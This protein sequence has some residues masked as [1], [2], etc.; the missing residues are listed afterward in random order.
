MI[1]H[2]KQT[3]RE[4]RWADAETLV[5]E[6][7]VTRPGDADLLNLHGIILHR[8]SRPTEALVRFEQA[9]DV[10]L[11]FPEA[12][13]N[14]ERILAELQNP[15][16]RYSVTVI[17]P[18]IGGVHLAQALQSVQEQTYPFLEHAIV[19]DGDQFR[20]AVEASLPSSPSKP[21]R[22][23]PLPSNTGARGF[24]GHRIYGALPHLLNSQFVAFLDEDN[25]FDKD[26]IASLMAHVTKAGLSWAYSLR[27]IVDANGILI[28]DD[29]CESLGQWPTWNNSDVH[30]VDV[31]CYLLR[32]DLAVRTSSLWYRRFRDGQS[33]DFL[34]CHDLLKNYPR[35]AT[36]GR[37][38]VNYRVGSTPSSVRAEFFLVGND[39]MRKR[40]SCAMPWRLT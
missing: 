28:T 25:W 36:N 16:P 6:A 32:R 18:T 4:R 38:T 3:L 9:T 31:N 24:N 5:A 30:L 23:Y 13:E 34:L 35:T 14:V 20:P 1:E 26:H 37:S 11:L 8:L 39:E 29:D 40:Y 21:I 33:P 12:W 22:V 19:I 2:I 27:C 7:I 10:R 17:T 15:E